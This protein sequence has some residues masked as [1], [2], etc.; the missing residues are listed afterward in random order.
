MAQPADTATDTGSGGGGGGAAFATVTD[1]GDD[2]TGADDVRTSAVTTCAP[3]ATP[4]ES[5]V[6]P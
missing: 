5:H 4:V 6:T 2:T 3:F 1:T